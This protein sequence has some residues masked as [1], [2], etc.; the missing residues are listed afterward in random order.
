[1][2]DTPAQ[3]ALGASTVALAVACAAMA[4]FLPPL[5]DATLASVLRTVLTGCALAT[6]LLLHW[7][8]LAIGARR[9]D[10]SVAGWV[11]LAVLLFPIGGVAAL[12]LLSFF[13]DETTAAPAPAPAAGG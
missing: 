1:M 4:A 3:R 7:V 9:L 11:S 2:P 12:I 10:R 5:L 8:F 6:G 13:G